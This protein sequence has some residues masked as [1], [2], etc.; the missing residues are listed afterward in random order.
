MDNSCELLFHWTENTCFDR[1]I[2]EVSVARFVNKTIISFLLNGFH[3][4]VHTSGFN[5]HS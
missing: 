2:M 1:W 5:T 3:M 4:N